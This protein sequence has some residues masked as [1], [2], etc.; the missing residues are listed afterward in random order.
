M[1][2][3]LANSTSSQTQNIARNIIRSVHTNSNKSETKT[4]LWKV[5]GLIGGVGIAVG[6][7]AASDDFVK[8]LPMD[9]NNNG[10][11]SSFDAASVRRGYEVYRQVCATCHSMSRVRF[12]DLIGVSHTETQAKALAE[13]YTV[14][15]GPNEKGEMFERPARLADSFPSPYPNEEFARAA[16]GGALPPDLSCIV[17]GRPGGADYIF[18]LLTG[19]R[20]APA[21]VQLRSG[22]HYNAY[23]SGGAIGMAKALN[24]EGIEYEDG[25]KATESQMSKDVSTF[26]AWASEPESDERKKFGMKTVI[27]LGVAA[28]F[29]A[30]NKRRIWNVIKTR[31]IWYRPTPPYKVH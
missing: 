25:T 16:N 22:L 8:P 7:V 19:Y 28:V 20:D 27:L 6:T 26:L 11:F 4:N 5:A 2:S 10:I 18:H 24:D 23:F 14:M 1:F 31:R 9:W 21:G 30:Y 12:R 13:S 17:K 29:A 3:R 15:D